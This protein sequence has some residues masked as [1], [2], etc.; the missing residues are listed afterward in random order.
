MKTEK[1][2]LKNETQSSCLCAVRQRISLLDNHKM[3]QKLFNKK[4]DELAQIM[5]NTMGCEI[6]SK[7]KY[8]APFRGDY[9]QF[10]YIA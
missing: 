6:I 7:I 10:Q 3:S 4:A 2:S 1:I 8:F 9:W 5:V